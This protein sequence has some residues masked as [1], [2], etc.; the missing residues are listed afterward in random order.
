MA[1]KW[2]AEKKKNFDKKQFA[3]LHSKGRYKYTCWVYFKT[4]HVRMGMSNRLYTMSLLIFSLKIC[5]NPTKN[6]CLQSKIIDKLLQFPKLSIIFFDNGSININYM[7]IYS[8]LT[9][10]KATTSSLSIIYLI[11]VYQSK[12]FWKVSVYFPYSKLSK[13]I[14]LWIQLNKNCTIKIMMHLYET[15]V[16]KII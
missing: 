16:A 15:K 7:C 8:K 14:V 12:F 2:F 6:E 4:N 1:N 11:Q 3:S 9:L 10:P 5:P 13:Y